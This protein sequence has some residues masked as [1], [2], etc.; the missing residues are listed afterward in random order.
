MSLRNYKKAFSLKEDCCLPGTEQYDEMRG[1]DSEFMTRCSLGLL[2]E[3]VR[4]LA[5]GL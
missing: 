4:S 2:E 5:L 1:V 3:Y